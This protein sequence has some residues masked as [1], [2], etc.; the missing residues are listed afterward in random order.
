M[1]GHTHLS[2]YLGTVCMCTYSLYMDGSMYVYAG[3]PLGTKSSLNYPSGGVSN[4]ESH[5]WRK[6]SP[7]SPAAKAVPGLRGSPGPVS[8]CRRREGD[9]KWSTAPPE[10]ILAECSHRHR[11]LRDAPAHS[12]HTAR[13]PPR[14]E[15]ERKQAFPP[16]FFVIGKDFKREVLRA[17]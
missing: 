17:S 16:F 7:A 5:G 12:H 2:I 15:G 9:P 14:R 10:A 6:V 3:I 4:P 13:V 1:S 11:W 8:C